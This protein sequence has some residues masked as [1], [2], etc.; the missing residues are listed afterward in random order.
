MYTRGVDNLSATIYRNTSPFAFGPTVQVAATAT[1]LANGATGSSGEVIFPSDVANYPGLG[2]G[3]WTSS[4]TSSG[5]GSSPNGGAVSMQ[6]LDNLPLAATPYYYAIRISTD[7]NSFGTP[8]NNA[9]RQGIYYL[10]IKLSGI[11]LN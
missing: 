10:P 6:I 2:T 11:F 8:L 5:A 4:C 9:N 7:T 1:N 3:L